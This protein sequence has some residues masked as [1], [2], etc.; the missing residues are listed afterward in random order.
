MSS[1]IRRIKVIKRSLLTG[2]REYLGHLAHI[3]I[4]NFD[5]NTK[6]RQEI[7]DSSLSRIISYLHIRWSLTF[8]TFKAVNREYAGEY[9]GE[10]ASEYYDEYAGEY[11]GY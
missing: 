9:S 2:P 10:Y 3:F 11:A 8:I 7:T 6:Y 5:F 1:T 4:T